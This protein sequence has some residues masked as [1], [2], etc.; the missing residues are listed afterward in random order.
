MRL[1]F[2]F[3]LFLIC[4]S[5]FLV[6]CDDKVVFEENADIENGVW[7]YKD[8]KSFE[9]DIQDTNSLFNFYVN[10]RNGEEYAYSN[11][12]VFV[13]MEFPNGKKSIDTLECPLADAYG[14]WYGRG[15]GKIFDNRILF[16]ERKRF[17]LS[18]HYKVGIYQAMRTD[19][20]AGIYDVGF[21]LA[22]SN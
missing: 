16:R 9:F 4:I 2:I 18:G 15:L 12:F 17:P 8:G 21:R 14:N 20:L 6:S 1:S 10:V 22:K 13:E 7:N 11:L 19:E 3:P 5:A